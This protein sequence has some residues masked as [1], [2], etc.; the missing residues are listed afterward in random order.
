MINS[1]LSITTVLVYVGLTWASLRSLYL[2]RAFLLRVNRVAAF[3]VVVLHGLLC[4]TG[5]FGDGGVDYSLH[6]LSI[7][8][9]YLMTLIVLLLNMRSRHA[10]LSTIVYV[11][12]AI[13]IFVAFLLHDP[14]SPKIAT[15]ASTYMH[16]LLSITAYA[17]LG[18]AALQTTLFTLLQ[19]WLHSKQRMRIIS[20]LPPLDAVEN[21]NVM[22]L[23]SG[24]VILSL[25]VIS[26]VLLYWERLSQSHY[27]LHTLVAVVAWILYAGI[28]VG[29]YGLGWRNRTT[30]LLSIIAFV[31][32]I[33]CYAGL[34]FA[35]QV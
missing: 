13:V 6:N 31:F 23:T 18:V 8:V 12:S 1:I 24:L 10:I 17:V 19:D 9:T 27:L 28:L 11:I 25:T 15:Q 14:A 26:A 16:I 33:G 21:L 34:R 2:R 7:L 22:L 5:T 4:F 29:R 32:L 35:T 30:N 3:V 20:L